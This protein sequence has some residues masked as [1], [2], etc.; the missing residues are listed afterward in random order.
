[1]LSPL[2]PKVN[3]N[4][5]GSEIHIIEVN[6]SEKKRK[7]KEKEDGVNSNI[8][9]EILFSSWHGYDNLDMYILRL[10][11]I[12]FM[13]VFV[14]FL[15]HSNYV[16]KSNVDHVTYGLLQTTLYGLRIGLAYVAMLVAM[17]YNG[18]VFLVGIVGHSLGFLFFGSRVF[19]KP[20]SG[21]NLDLPPIS[22][23]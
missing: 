20:S 11:V 13:R 3:G 10:V 9:I 23:S 19:K 8:V 7:G 2:L 12:F 5:F 21:K 15:S 22:C 18:G 16:Y 4:P 1:M 6:K 14:E 17:S